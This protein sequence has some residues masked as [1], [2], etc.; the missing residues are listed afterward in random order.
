MSL[1]SSDRSR[2]I[3]FYWL[4]RERHRPRNVECQFFLK[5]E[6]ILIMKLMK[7]NLLRTPHY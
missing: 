6:Q 7:N 2:K 3:V 1:E 4:S 5:G